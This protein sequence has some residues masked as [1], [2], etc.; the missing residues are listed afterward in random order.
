MHTGHLAAAVTVTLSLPAT[1]G[2]VLLV[3]VVMGLQIL[4]FGFIFPGGAR[5]NHF[6]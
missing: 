1:Y 3:G 6:T 5:S 4:L 2:Y